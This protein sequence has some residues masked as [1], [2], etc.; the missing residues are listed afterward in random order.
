MNIVFYKQMYLSFRAS[1]SLSFC[2]KSAVIDSTFPL[3]TVSS[4]F[5]NSLLVELSFNLRNIHHPQ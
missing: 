1:I 3:A 5:S 4:P 2:A